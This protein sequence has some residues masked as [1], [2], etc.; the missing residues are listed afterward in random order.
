MAI[1]QYRTQKELIL[2]VQTKLSSRILLRQK[3]LGIPCH[4]DI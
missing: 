3:D 1:H 2:T 4:T